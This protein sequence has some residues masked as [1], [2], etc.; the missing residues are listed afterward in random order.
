MS[1]DLY[2]KGDQKGDPVFRCITSGCGAEYPVTEVIYRCRSCGGLLEVWHPRERWKL[3][4][5]NTWRE[6]WQERRKFSKHPWNSGVWRFY[7]WVLPVIP[8][9]D[10]VSLGEGN[11]P[12]LPAPHFS[13]SLGMQ[14]PIH[15]KQCGT[16]H[17]GS[18]KDLGMTVLISMVHHLR[19]SGVPIPA[20]ICASTGDTSAA[21]A[22][23]GAFAGIPTIVLLPRAK[24]SVAQLIQPICN[25]ALVLEVESDFDGCMTLV[26]TLVERHGLYL[27]N[28]L[29]SLRIEGQKTV[30]YEIIEQLE[31]EPPDYV[32][33]PG[34]N[35]GNVSALAKGFLDLEAVGLL[36][37]RPRI[38]CAQVE[39]ANPLY[40]SFLQGFREFTP[41]SA[42]ETLA[43]AIR[44]GNPVSFPKAVQALKEF[45]GI[46]TSISEQALSDAA[47]WADRSGMFSCPHTG[48]ALASLIQLKEEGV[49][50]SNDR[51]VV[52]S[53]AHGLKF[54]EFK[55][56]Y[57]S[58]TLTGIKPNYA[59]RSLVVPQ[60]PETAWKAIS[61]RLPLSPQ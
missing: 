55:V 4:S 17:T 25:G 56:G 20:V 35:L 37:R 24:V 11:T 40:L 16:T 27:A 7:E 46:V 33:I 28:S 39:S 23:Y 15:I 53:T 19:R 8:Y 49:I 12:L 21:L 22:A 36:T 42:G 58:G 34:G 29:N 5:A 41:V 61:E 59:N 43:S 14:H 1:L 13:R 26:Q 51:V 45:D 44:I 6:L 38:V 30:A 32:I 57:Q 3:N 50:T 2:Q 48:V 52:I 18:F 54:S 9:E 10:I 47:H 31:F 60:D